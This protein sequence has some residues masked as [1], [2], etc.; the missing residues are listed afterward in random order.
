MV[1]FLERA[2]RQGKIKDQLYKTQFCGIKTELLLSIL[3]K[4][5]VRTSVL[6]AQVTH[7]PPAA[8]Q[9]LAPKPPEKLSALNRCLT[10]VFRFKSKSGSVPPPATPPL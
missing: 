5:A 3:V 10:I 1:L 6:N 4:A 9:Q 8:R 7:N 2:S